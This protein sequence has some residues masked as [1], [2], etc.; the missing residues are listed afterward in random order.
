[1]PDGALLAALDHFL[2]AASAAE[3]RRV[4]AAL[5][6]RLRRALARAFR[7]QGR[8]LLRRAAASPLAESARLREALSDDEWLRLFDLTAE[9]TAQMFAG[10]LEQGVARALRRGAQAIAR[11]MQV[12]LTRDLAWT[13]ENPRAAAYIE[14]HG[15]ALVRGI[16]DTT[17]DYLRTV[18]RQAAQEGWSYR[19][20]A[21]VI[22]GRFAEFAAGVPQQHLR[23][24]AEL[25]AVHEVG[26]AYETGTRQIVDDLPFRIEKSWLTVGDARVSALCAANQAAGWISSADM[27]PSG[28]LH[29]SGHPGCRCTCLYRRA[30]SD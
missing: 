22:T 10:P 23:S 1:M 2:E 11:S 24:R 7:A 30:E 9:E 20:T 26:T 15:A 21:D 6:E 17:R 13:I 28:H 16:D 14:Q 19:Y 25:I 27:F 5:E 4:T 8:G 12:D 3:K 18:L 29:P